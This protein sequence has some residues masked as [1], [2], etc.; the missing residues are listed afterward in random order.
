MD[1][2]FCFNHGLYGR[3]IMNLRIARKIWKYG[4]WC[5]YYWK[6]SK[7]T[8]QQ[9]DKASKIFLNHIVRGVR[10]ESQTKT[11]TVQKLR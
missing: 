8:D 6:L 10:N 9:H 4:W 7:Y 5:D 11:K 1:R 2:V 3:W